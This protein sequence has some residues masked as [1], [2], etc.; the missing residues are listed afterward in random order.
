[1]DKPQLQSFDANSY[2]QGVWLSRIILF[3]TSFVNL[4]WDTIYQ[5][6][7]IIILFDKR[8]HLDRRQA[9]GMINFPRHKPFPEA[10]EKSS[11]AT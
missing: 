10:L 6:N 7:V 9:Q 2:Q 11:S 3:K 8:I 4:L 1:M 5:H